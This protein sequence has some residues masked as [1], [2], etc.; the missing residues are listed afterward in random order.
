[1]NTR[2]RFIL[3]TGTLLLAIV[4]LTG[5]VVGAAEVPAMVEGPPMQPLLEAPCTLVDGTRSCE[6]WALPGTLTM[7]DGLT[8]PVWGF[9]TSESGPALVPGPV[10]RANAGEIVE[11]VLHNEV[12]EERIS[13]AFPAQEGL[14]DLDGI[15]T[16]EEKSYTLAPPHPGTFLYEA[17]LTVGGARQVAMGLFGPFIVEEAGPPAWHQEV[18]LVLSEV[19]PA[20]NANPTTFSMAAFKPKY[21]LINGKAF[22]D[23]G[24]I[25]TI[26]GDTV[27]IRYLNAGVQ[28][29]PIG[30]L[31]LYQQVVNANGDPL[32]FPRGAIAEPLAAGETRDVLVDIPLEAIT[33][34][35]YAVYDSSLRHHNN[36]QRLSDRRAA[37]GG[38]LA[39]F[40][41]TAGASPGDL[42]PVATN[43][44]V[45]PDHAS[46]NTDIVLSA[47]LSDQD[48]VV[49]FEYFVNV[50]GDPG[51]G[52]VTEIVS[53][54]PSV[55]VAVTIPGAIVAT[56][57]SG[58]HTLYIRGQDEAG[59]W[60]S[61]GSA[62]L[63]VDN[64]GPVI[65]GLGLNP[66]P[67]NGLVAVAI[68]ATADDSTTGN[69]NVVAGEYQLDGG[70]WEP[71]LVA[72]SGSPVA[73]LSATIPAETGLTE[74]SHLVEVRA[75]DE[76]GNWTT[77]PGTA[78]LVVD[79]TG[80][81]VL[82]ASLSP[83]VVDLNQPLPPAVRLAAT[84]ED[85]L[86][87]GVQTVVAN[88]E[89][90][91]DAVGAPGTGFALYPA[92]G[93]YDETVEDAY[94]D[95]PSVA[96]VALSP[97]VHEVLVV[98]QDSVGNRGT[99]GSAMITI[100]AAEDDTTGPTV[101]NVVATPN[102]AR[103]GDLVTLTATA[104]DSQSAIAA[105]V[106]FQGTNPAKAKTLYPMEP[107]DGAFDQL[108]ED[109]VATIDLTRWRAT[110]YQI[111]VRARDAAGNWGPLTTIDL[112]VT[113]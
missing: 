107:I 23:T 35:A 30:L 55:D 50:V 14:P 57:H 41:V 7:P 3:T 73:G 38:M 109:V 89:A 96:F 79:T 24:W 18:V 10:I 12:P 16:G 11:I 66:N 94:Y 6:L 20:F 27:L 97:G 65:S 40:K 102:P 56:W 53:P 44:T 92:D 42:G 26:A 33:D 76:A 62:S 108:T 64:D 17:G 19:D 2:K 5:L 22:P 113:R 98:G 28:M 8:V 91:I 86:S 63:T 101:S 83:D 46:G 70:G 110:T 106:W 112:V 49:A 59:N 69:S 15:A 48:N 95:I 58:S 51:T 105:V 100:I 67:T 4:A 81:V 74:G 25:G 1:M 13:L 111:S 37:F 45:T 84:L 71:M 93:L 60:G 36:N 52:E 88:A 78:L 32:P 75:L 77:V 43:V 99:A 104:T 29:H 90:F 61:L 54:A 68:N 85:P 80:P 82:S 21:W 9:A 39:F 47:T 72:P 31:G 34:T 87:G 103:I